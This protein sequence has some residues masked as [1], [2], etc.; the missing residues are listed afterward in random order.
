MY[1]ACARTV[2]Y[3]LRL[4]CDSQARTNTLSWYGPAGET[5]LGR[6]QVDRLSWTGTS[7][8]VRDRYSTDR[9]FLCLQ[10]SARYPGRI[11]NKQCFHNQRYM[12]TCLV[13]VTRTSSKWHLRL[14]LKEKIQGPERKASLV[15]APSEINMIQ[16]RTVHEKIIVPGGSILVN[17][18]VLMVALARKRVLPL[19]LVKI[20]PVLL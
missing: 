12:H 2:T 8:I 17:I 9:V 18:V 1:L 6:N 5:R 10:V 20:H 7:Y 15:P 19:K 3:M 16:I 14:Q 11:D 4:G 13:S